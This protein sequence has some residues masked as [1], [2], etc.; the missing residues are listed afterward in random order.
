MLITNFCLVSASCAA[1]RAVVLFRKEKVLSK[2]FTDVDKMPLYNLDY[3]NSKADLPINQY[4]VLTGKITSNNLQPTFSDK[5]VR[6]ILSTIVPT[7]KEKQKDVGDGLLINLGQV[8][9]FKRDHLIQFILRNDNHQLEVKYLP[10]RS[11]ILYNLPKMRE[12]IM[13]SELSQI[14]IANQHVF[15]TTYT[16]FA[17]LPN[18]QYGVCGKLQQDGVLTPLIILGSSK[19]SF[20]DSLEEELLK[21]NKAA[22]IWLLCSGGITIAAAIYARMYKRSRKQKENQ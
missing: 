20:I 8:I 17:L 15:Q 12:N 5:S 16:E 10:N 1:L 18:Q 13:K 14:K 7:I 11:L 4:L 2:M 22:K 19:E 6:A 21:I 3:I 9:T